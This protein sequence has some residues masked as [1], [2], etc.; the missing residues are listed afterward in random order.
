MKK[1]HFTINRECGISL[2][3]QLID[4][5]KKSIESGFFRPGDTLPGFREIANETGA[6]MVV[7]R[8]AM[9]RL[10]EQGYVVLRRGV[11]SI[12]LDAAQKS[13][14]RG[15]IVISSLEV[16]ENQL[17]SAMTG[18]LRQALMKA[19]YLVSYVPFNSEVPS[20]YDFTHLDSVLTG[21]ISLVVTTDSSKTV[22]DHLVQSGKPFVTFGACPEAATS[23]P[24]DCSQ[25]IRG[26]ARHC[27]KT[28]VRKVIEVT[29]GSEL[30]DAKSA[31]EE[32]GIK[33][34][35]WPIVKRGGIEAIAKG[36]LKAFYSRMAKHAKAWLPDV[37]YFNDNFACQSALLVLLEAGVDIPQDVKIVTWSNKG[38]GPF[39]RKT[40]ARIEIDPFEAGRIFARHILA[41]L[42]K[43][44]LPGNSAI[45]PR[46]IPG[47]TFPEAAD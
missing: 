13:F 37:L 43:K 36:T 47:E 7:V 42:N 44:R 29:V 19:G 27:K 1:L 14:W 26:F 41:F 11:G 20:E 46:F 22:T 2:I 9:Q 31:L 39:W 15:H 12:V 33:C 23:I 35:R 32:H 4:G 24:L 10:S 38:E 25:A 45:S 3:N 34:V 6:C 8:Q 18:A 5:I 17:L 16:R 40:L 30:A 28:G 21:P